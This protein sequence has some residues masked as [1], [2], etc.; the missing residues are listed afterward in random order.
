[1]TM[2]PKYLGFDPADEDSDGLAD[3]LTGAGPWDTSDFVAAEISDGLAH[4]LSITSTSDL[5]AITF[6]ITGTDADG[7]EISE[8]IVGPN[9]A[10]VESTKYFKSISAVSVSA[11]VGSATFDIG[12]VDEFA[13]RTIPLE[14]YAK[15][16]PSVQVGLTGTMGFDIEVTNSDIRDSMPTQDSLTWVD[17]AN[18]TGKSASMVAN[19]SG[20]VRACRFVAN[21]YSSGA[22]IALAII[23][24]K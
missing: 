15:N 19:L 1:M 12:W 23:T 7:R 10:A 14:I 13:S 2:R 18:F 5:S 11:T 3:G 8:A 6:T 21:S 9:N 22:S 16:P 4:Q 17:D 20:I 24:S